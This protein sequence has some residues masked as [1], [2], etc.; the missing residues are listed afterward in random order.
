M[1]ASSAAKSTNARFAAKA[2]FWAI[3]VH[4]MIAVA[5]GINIFFQHGVSSLPEISSDS[6]EPA[7]VQATAIEESELEKEIALIREREADRRREELERQQSVEA[8][9]QEQELLEQQRKQEQERL[10]SITKQR[11]HEERRA[12]ELEELR[13]SQEEQVQRIEQERKRE[14]DELAALE[15]QRKSAAQ[16]LEDLKREQEE[17]ERK[18]IAERERET[19]ELEKQRLAE[20]REAERRR[21]EQ[22]QEQAQ[23]KLERIESLKDRARSEMAK[24]AEPIKQK[25]ERNWVRA[26]TDSQSEAGVVVEVDPSGVVVSAVIIRSSGSTQFDRSV[27]H[28]IQKASPLPIPKDP[29]IYDYIR[30]F[31]FSFKTPVNT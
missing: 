9:R 11:E 22:E 2:V 15:A 13:R 4:L 30:K 3:V 23:A 12:K 7:T 8:A 17:A 29:E 31:N 25:V 26:D 28:A 1:P 14:A 19:E 18:R 21:L 24:F 6:P 27:L 10:A 5:F 20:E 16:A